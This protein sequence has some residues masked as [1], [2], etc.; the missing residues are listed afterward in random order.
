MALEI[1]VTILLILCVVMTCIP[2][3]PGL[4][5]MFLITLV[6]GVIDGFEKLQPWQLA[7]FGGITL[8]SLAI[9]AF[10]GVL[11][12][13]L[14]GASRRAFL[15]GIVGLFVG[16]LLFPPWGAFIGLFLGVF[17]AEVVQFKDFMQAFKKASISLAA[18]AA[19]TIA[20]VFL[21]TA[22]LVIYLIIVF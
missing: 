3:L 5:L 15:A 2:T 11:G 20:N 9:D 22:Y 6:Y 4:P 12:A 17:I 16:F 13:K 18:A 7:V 14:G 1:I 19:G 21:A 10:S 8:L